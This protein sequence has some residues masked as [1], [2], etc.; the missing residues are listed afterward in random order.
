M[1]HAVNAPLRVAT[2]PVRRSTLPPGC[3]IEPLAW[4]LLDERKD[5]EEEEEPKIAELLR[6]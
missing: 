2:P 1:P 4:T 3:Y 6:R 5:K